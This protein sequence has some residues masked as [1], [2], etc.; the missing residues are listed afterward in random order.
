MAKKPLPKFANEAEEVAFY[1]AHQE[2]LL[3]YFEVVTGQNDPGLGFD[4]AT[5]RTTKPVTMRLAEQD[6]IRAKRIAA[7]KGV[8]YQTLIKMAIREWLDSEERKAQ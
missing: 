2:D 5:L 8:G 3:E 1:E 6:V 4:P 7:R